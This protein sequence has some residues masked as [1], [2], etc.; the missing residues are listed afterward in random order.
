MEQ[1]QC[2]AKLQ[3]RKDKMAAR[4]SNRRM[5]RKPQALRPVIAVVVD[6]ET[7]KWYIEQLK[8]FYQPKITRSIRITP[9]LPQV[10]KVAELFEYAHQLIEECYTDVFLIIDLDVILG[11]EEERKSF[12]RLYERSLNPDDKHQWMKKLTVIINTPCLEYWYLLHF[13]ST[14]RFFNNYDSLKSDLQKASPLMKAYDKNHSFYNNPPGLFVKLYSHLTNARDNSKEFVLDEMN[15]K[16]GSEMFKLF[17]FID[18]LS[19]K[20]YLDS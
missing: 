16:G 5:P 3:L 11:N 10:K 13:K 6:G 17:D 8:K 1:S 18:A 4:D 7:E 14:T 19:S 20:P 9:Q 2:L 12:I 15:Q